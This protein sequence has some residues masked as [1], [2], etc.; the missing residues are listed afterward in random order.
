MN[1]KFEQI[2]TMERGGNNKFPLIFSSGF[3]RLFTKSF[4]NLISLDKF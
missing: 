2:V 3:I 4:Q 1:L